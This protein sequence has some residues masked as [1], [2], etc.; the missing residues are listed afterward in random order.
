MANSK[1]LLSADLLERV[2]A[3]LGLTDR[4]ALDLAGLNAVYA[5]WSTSVPFD[6]IQK[7]IWFAGDRSKPVTGSDPVAFFENWL[8]D[9]TGGTC[10]PT[11]GATATLLDTL[12]F[13]T[14][15]IAGAM[16]ETSEVGQ[17]A[18]HGSVIVT[19]DDAQF[20]VDASMS[21]FEVLPLVA[22]EQ[23]AAGAGIHAIA[24]NPVDGGFEVGWYPGH[25]RDRLARFRTD[26]AYDPVD[27]A[28]FLEGYAKSIASGPFNDALYICRRYRES[29][30]TVRSGQKF[31]TAVDGRVSVSALSDGDRKGLLV[32]ELGYGED[33]VARIPADAPEG[34]AD[35]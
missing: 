35:A 1:P 13:D 7:R 32:A 4:P 30:I 23:T 34:P 15:R 27:H 14:R 20:L 5:A 12:G 18:G 6:N 24:A 17:P 2:L 9:G 21:A 31:V 26:A 10:W 3:K 16:I 29:I 33:I 22:G 25:L 8:R 28:F 11:S 19:I